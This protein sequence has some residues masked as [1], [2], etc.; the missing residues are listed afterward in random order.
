CLQPKAVRQTTANPACKNSSVD[1][2]ERTNRGVENVS[3]VPRALKNAPAVCHSQV[4]WN[5]QANVT[6]QIQGKL[7]EKVHPYGRSRFRKDSD[8]SPVGVRW[9]LRS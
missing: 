2:C 8:N 1:R 5:F 4:L 9:L 7:H 6:E 3:M